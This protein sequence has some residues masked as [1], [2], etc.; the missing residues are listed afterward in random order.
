[1]LGLRTAEGVSLGRVREAT[2]V[3]LREGREPAITRRCDRGDLIDDGQTLRVPH[4]RWLSLDAIV[5]DLF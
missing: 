5:T 2:G 1:M 4:E 3:D